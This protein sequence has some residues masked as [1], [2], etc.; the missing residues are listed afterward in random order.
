MAKVLADY[1]SALR[2]QRSRGDK[3]D[4]KN[5]IYKYA[6]D[7]EVGSDKVITTATNREAA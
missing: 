7:R 1:S 6:T 3:I 4:N 2:N 5:V